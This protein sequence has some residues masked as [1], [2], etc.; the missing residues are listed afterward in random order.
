MKK[1]RVPAPNVRTRTRTLGI[2]LRQARGQAALTQVEA[3]RLLRC[4]QS[5]ISRVEG[6]KRMPTFL[7]VE[8]FAVAYQVKMGFFMTFRRRGRF[9]T[10]Y[11]GFP[12]SEK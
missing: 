4:D 9:K 8:R 3:A 11:P 6:G 5:F 12:K 10:G 7:E 2:R 1:V